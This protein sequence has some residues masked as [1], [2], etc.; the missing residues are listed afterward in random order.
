MSQF[1]QNYGNSDVERRLAELTHLLTN[2]PVGTANFQKLEPELLQRRSDPSHIQA[3]M[4]FVQQGKSDEKNMLFAAIEIKN[5]II[6]SYDLF[7]EA[8]KSVNDSFLNGFREQLLQLYF[9]PEIGNLSERVSATISSALKQLVRREFPFLWPELTDSIA[10]H[11]SSNN[12][13]QNYL[14]LLILKQ[15]TKDYPSRM[16]TEENL[17]ELRLVTAKFHDLLIE[18]CQGYI[19]YLQDNIVSPKICLKMIA[20]L[21]RI[22]ANLIAQGSEEVIEESVV[23]WTQLLQPLFSA[24]LNAS[25]N[26]QIEQEIKSVV[27]NTRNGRHESNLLENWFDCKGEAVKVLTLLAARCDEALSAEI[28][29]FANSIW[30]NCLQYA[31]SPEARKSRLMIH[32]LKYF[33]SLA[34][35]Q[36]YFPFFEKNVADILTKLVIPTLSGDDESFVLFESDPEAFVESLLVVK[37]FENKKKMVIHDF[38]TSLTRFHRDNVFGVIETMF[39]ELLANRSIENAMNEALFMEVFYDAT[40]ISFNDS[41]ATAI[42]CPLNFL[43]YVYENLVEQIVDQFAENAQSLDKETQ[44]KSTFLI[45]N[46]LQFARLFANLIGYERVSMLVLKLFCLTIAVPVEPYQKMLIEMI[47]FMFKTRTFT[48]EDTMD[49]DV[50][51]LSFYQRYFNNPQRVTVRQVD[52]NYMFKID[53]KI[54]VFS[55]VL[56]GL[57]WYMSQKVDHIDQRSLK[58]LRTALELVGEKHIGR[59]QD[60]LLQLIEASIN[61][62]KS[63]KMALNFT[64]INLLF[65]MLAAL[66]IKVQQGSQGRI[67]GIVSFI[68][69][70]TSADSLELTALVFQTVAL[71]ISRFQVSLSSDL[72]LPFRNLLLQAMNTRSYNQK[73]IGIFFA[74]FTLIQEAIKVDSSIL[75]QRINDVKSILNESNNLL[76]LRITYQ[77]LKYLTIQRLPIDQ[78]ITFSTSSLEMFYSCI[79]SNNE[80]ARKFAFMKPAFLKEFFELVFISS[81]VDSFAAFYNRM[82]GHR[83]ENQ[84]KSILTSEDSVTFLSQNSSRHFRQFALFALSKVLFDEYT[85]FTSNGLADEYSCLLNSTLENIWRSKFD[86]RSLRTNYEAHRMEHETFNEITDSNFTSI[87]RL[88]ELPD[89]GDEFMTRFKKE[90]NYK[91]SGDVYFLEGF[92]NFLLHNRLNARD[93]VRDEKHLKLLN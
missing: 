44:R 76:Q 19:G 62:L 91:Q 5:V 8:R 33:K 15:I 75:A 38:V 78:L 87:Y 26:A 67:H 28:D 66:M 60:S 10:A 77:F 39:S 31:S 21:L 52:G 14:S 40:V 12:H 51:K 69:Q 22:Y 29:S 70:M 54:D 89:C 16:T 35:S 48:I 11:L 50:S 68:A 84:F 61:S 73:T 79:N 72:G 82:K 43:T 88:R 9:Q 23:S 1:G 17:E 42:C 71:F 37:N 36:K 24:E 80:E 59:Y 56:E 83:V 13:R 57:M 20:L 3:L 7:A 25:I 45:C 58:T 49:K 4:L 65:E 55:A 63:N 2:N 18:F 92:K 27:S 64:V 85:F 74:Y 41:G 53:A 6:D 46:Y 34:A 90:L 47:G 32:S 81:V 30:N 86:F 93:V